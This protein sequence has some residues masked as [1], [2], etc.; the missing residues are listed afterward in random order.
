V[1]RTPYQ[2]SVESLEP[3]RA[4]VG[5]VTLVGT[6]HVS[7]K[8]V[9]EVEEA[10][11]EIQP[12]AV[13][14][15]LDETRLQALRDPHAWAQLPVLDLIK[16]GKGPQLLAQVLLS[17]YQR[18]IGE[19]TG[20]RPGQ[21]LLSAVEAAEALDAEVVLADRDVGTTLRRAFQ[22][23]PLRE[24]ARVAWEM[25]KATFAEEEGEEFD[26]EDVDELLEED[27]LTQ[28][29]EEMAELAPSASHVL[30]DE[31][32]AYMST[33]I[34]DAADRID[35]EL[36]AVVGAGH[37]RGVE[38]ALREQRRANLEVLESTDSSGVP[39][40][41]AFAWTLTAIVLGLFALLA[42]EALTTGDAQKLGIGA[43]W[44][45]VFSGIPASLGSIIAGGGVLTTIVAFLASPL[46]SLNPAVAAGW[47]AGAVEAWRREP[48][49]GDIEGLSEI[50][51]FAD[52]RE[53]GLVRVI[54]VAA[55][56]NLGSI[57]GSW[58]GAA[59]LVEV[60]T[61]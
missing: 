39:W 24:K 51:T 8:S 56:V 37:M 3:V 27:A 10:I 12:E 53:N 26:A 28:A 13:C 45:L 14:V 29:M 33:E 55:L 42:Y 16:E 31:R 58:A 34:L 7:P 49:V 20:V 2:G 57:V 54:L 47:F 15:E 46:T 21:E 35:G 32:D 40:G 11:E 9:E 44:Y 6:A 52:M 50:Y 38:E 19:E 61:G 18:R 59:K 1:D 22:A 17:S 5:D 60:V 41:K 48:T 25:V 23:M 43:A 4:Q 30:I 36:V